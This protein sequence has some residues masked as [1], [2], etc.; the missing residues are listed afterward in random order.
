ME[1]YAVALVDEAEARRMSAGALP[2]ATESSPVPGRFSGG[3]KG[4]SVR[5][6]D[7]WRT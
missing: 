3:E 1:D 7:D 2:S 6:G 5:D 4:M